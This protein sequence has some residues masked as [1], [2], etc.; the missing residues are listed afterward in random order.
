MRTPYGI[1]IAFGCLLSS[2]FFEI[3]IFSEFLLFSKL[4]II[5]L[6]KGI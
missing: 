3:F 1:R 4:D 6:I 2:K 5:R